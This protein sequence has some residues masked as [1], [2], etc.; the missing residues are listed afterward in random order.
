MPEITDMSII[1][2]TRDNLDKAR[3]DPE[4]MFHI[5]FRNGY[6]KGSVLYM[7][8]YPETPKNICR[9]S[10]FCTVKSTVPNMPQIDIL[11]YHTDPKL[12][13]CIRLSE[14]T[15]S[16]DDTDMFRQM[17]NIAEQTAH[18]IADLLN[19]WFPESITIKS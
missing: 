4:T 1:L 3:T 12:Q 5:R 17:L 15:V 11:P 18:Q 19:E 9:T 7:D 14:L 16:I 13:V 2:H 10:L 8:P 6:Y